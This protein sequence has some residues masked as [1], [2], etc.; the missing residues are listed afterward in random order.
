MNPLFRLKQALERRHELQKLRALQSYYEQKCRRMKKIK[1]KKYVSF[2]LNS[3]SLNEDFTFAVPV[4]RYHRIK[5][6][7]EK[8]ANSTQ[9]FEQLQKENPELAQV[10]LQKA[11]KLRVQVRR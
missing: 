9:T 6:K 4:S 11:E 1:S 3:F 5:R 8:K 7:G 10:E 2:W